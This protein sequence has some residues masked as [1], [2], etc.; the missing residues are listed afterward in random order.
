MELLLTYL[1]IG[2]VAGIVSHKVLKG[3]SHGVGTD[4]V[5]GAF[6]AYTAATLVTVLGLPLTGFIPGL[7][8]SLAGALALPVIVTFI[9]NGK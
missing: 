8:I 5:V 6:G 1:V 4:T 9:P 7:V 2:F 3:P